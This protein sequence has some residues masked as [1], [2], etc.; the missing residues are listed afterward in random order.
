MLRPVWRRTPPA[1][2]LKLG[3][4]AYSAWGLFHIPDYPGAQVT[5]K[6]LMNLYRSRWAHRR[7]S[8]RL[9]SLPVKLTI[10]PWNVCNL[11][12]PACFTGLGETGRAKTRMSMPHYR[13]LLDEL[14]DTLWQVEFC[15]WGEPLLVKDINEMIRDAHERG[16]S[17]L[18]STNFSLRFDEAAA[19]RL[20]RS[21][22]SVL[23]VS[24]DGARQESYEQYRVRG[25]LALVLRNCALVRDA[26]KRLQSATPRLVWEYHVFPFNTDDVE[27]A[28]AMADELD[29]EIAVSKGWLIGPDWD[30]DG[31]W[32]D[33]QTTMPMPCSFLWQQAVVDN[34]GGVAPC[35]GTFYAEDDMG[36]LESTPGDGG[37]ATFR[38][39]W[40]SERYQQGRR[41]FQSRTGSPEERKHVCFACPVTVEFERFR[42]HVAAGRP[43]TDFR[44]AANLHDGFNYFWSRRPT[45]AQEPKA[46]RKALSRG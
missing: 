37:A 29:M 27:A 5:P 26:K 41:F 40:N 10:E 33:P 42:A 30:P 34:D 15:N 6:R 9:P 22:L 14:G 44:S 13:R 21:G 11:R 18:L 12:C 38:E 39:A 1:L 8:T 23:G 20:V 46:R 7:L 4:L 43:A 28:R 16:I 2:Q 25:D 19:E 35:C 24:I 31:A 17:T 32:V 45:T 3:R 36:R